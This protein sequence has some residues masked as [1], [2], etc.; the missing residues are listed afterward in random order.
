MYET[1]NR[2]LKKIKNPPKLINNVHKQRLTIKNWTK[3]KLH[4]TQPYA[5]QMHTLLSNGTD[6]MHDW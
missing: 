6:P 5:I 1:I 2:H 4:S 3:K